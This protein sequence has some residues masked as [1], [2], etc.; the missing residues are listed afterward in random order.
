MSL[1]KL[2]IENQCALV[3][4]IEYS[5]NGGSLCEYAAKETDPLHLLSCGVY[6]VSVFGLVTLISNAGIMCKHAVLL[7]AIL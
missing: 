7:T 1:S 3:L 4:G 2:L 5:Q 6:Y